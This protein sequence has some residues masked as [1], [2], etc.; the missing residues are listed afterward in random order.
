[1]MMPDNIT[2][3]DVQT[4]CEH[5]TTDYEDETASVLSALRDAYTGVLNARIDMPKLCSLERQLADAKRAA[6]ALDWRPNTV[7]K[8]KAENHWVET[9]KDVRLEALD[10]SVGQQ[11]VGV[12]DRQ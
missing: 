8:L 3:V 6:A 7:K 1:M 9:L 4:I 2:V 12:G 11:A 5:P 10:Y